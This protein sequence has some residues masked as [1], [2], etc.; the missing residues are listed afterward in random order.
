MTNRLQMSPSHWLK[1]TNRTHLYLKVHSGD[2]WPVSE[3]RTAGMSTDWIDNHV[4]LP[5]LGSALRPHTAVFGG[6]H[7]VR[8]AL[9][10]RPTA[11]AYCDVCLLFIT[12]PSSLFPRHLIRQDY[13]V[14]AIRRRRIAVRGGVAMR[15]SAKHSLFV[16]DFQTVSVVYKEVLS[17]LWYFCNEWNSVACNTTIRC[18][19][20]FPVLIKISCLTTTFRM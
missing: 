10:P 12:A 17:W 18:L 16:T 5:W 8:S 4:T 7:S 13:R 19:F 11:R 6:R 15:K 3:C 2:V 14:I 9:K 1:D 20:C